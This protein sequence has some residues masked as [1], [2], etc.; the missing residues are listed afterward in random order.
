MSDQPLRGARQCTALPTYQ[1]KVGVIFAGRHRLEN[2]LGKMRKNLATN[3]P[4]RFLSART[5][6]ND[7]FVYRLGLQVFILAR[8]VRLPYGSPLFPKEQRH[9]WLNKPPIRAPLPGGFSILRIILRAGYENSPLRQP[10][11]E[12]AIPASDPHPPGVS[13]APA[14]V[15]SFDIPAASGEPVISAR[16]R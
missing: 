8:R 10:P 9:S 16:P 12:P 7:P 6:T 4:L 2:N 1:A 11:V 15:R 3:P 14:R 5:A 13:S